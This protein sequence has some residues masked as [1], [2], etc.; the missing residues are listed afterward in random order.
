VIKGTATTCSVFVRKWWRKDASG[1]KVP[2]PGAPR[3][4]IAHNCTEEE[5][6]T[7]AQEYNATHSPGWASRKAEYEQE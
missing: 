2:Y 4:Y 7:I 5:A 6:R 3:R 1:F